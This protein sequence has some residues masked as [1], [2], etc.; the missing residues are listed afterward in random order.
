MMVIFN[1]VTLGSRATHRQSNAVGSVEY[2]ERVLEYLDIDFRR[3]F[4]G[5]SS[6]YKK[7]VREDGTW[8]D[9]LCFTRKKNIYGEQYA[10]KKNILK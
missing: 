5:D 10:R 3:V 8:V 1:G 7:I 9:E 4:L 2:D 6:E